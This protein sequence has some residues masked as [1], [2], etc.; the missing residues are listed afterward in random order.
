MR[1]P[2]IRDFF[3]L[4]FWGRDPS[5]SAPELPALH[6]QLAKCNEELLDRIGEIGAL[7]AQIDEQNARLRTYEVKLRTAEEDR[8]GAEVLCEKI[9]NTKAP[10]RRKLNKPVGALR[11]RLRLGPKPSRARLQGALRY[12]IDRSRVKATGRTANHARVSGW[13]VDVEAGKA[14]AVRIRIGAQVYE[15]RRIS[16]EDVQRQL[17]T[18]C[19]LPLETGFDLAI[20]IA[21]G[22]SRLS[23]E[24]QSREGSWVRI[25]EKL[26]F[27]PPPWMVRIFRSVRSLRD[28]LASAPS[29][30]EWLQ[31]ENMRSEE[32]LP[33]FKKHAK[34]MVYQP[35]FA[36]VVDDREGRGLKET[37]A[38]IQH[39][40]YEG[41]RLHMSSGSA[42]FISE[43]PFRK[44]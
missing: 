22:L 38:S 6:K 27:S 39:Q 17:S 35:T 19:T 40:I 12:H 32:E 36:I 34:L 8:C 20:E 26:L 11:K 25:C 14:A 10:H 33:E 28:F 16:R 18:I 24:L 5:T 21:P 44:S 13:A 41:W 43:S 42:P 1:A 2:N 31:R 3:E 30:K 15:P 37:V 9:E 4:L 29:Y 7:R 23:I